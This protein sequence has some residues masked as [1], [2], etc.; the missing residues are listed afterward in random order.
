MRSLIGAQKIKN[1]VEKVLFHAVVLGL[2]ILDRG[3]KNKN[4]VEKVLF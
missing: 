2:E 4:R 1:R 3:A